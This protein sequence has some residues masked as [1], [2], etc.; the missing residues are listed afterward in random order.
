MTFASFATYCIALAIAVV[1]PGPGVMALIGT[2]LGGG[3]KRAMPMIIGIA[4]GDATWLT[5]AVL[6]LAAISEVY[7]EAFTII[8]YLGVAYLL[9]LAWKF[10]TNT[11]ELKAEEGASKRSAFASLLNGYLITMGNPKPMLFYLA[12]V[13]VILDLSAFGPTELSLV[14]VATFV[15]LVVVLTPY[16]LLASGAREWLKSSRV[17]KIMNRTAAAL[18]GTAAIVIGLRAH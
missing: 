14:V 16:A 18:I 11:S 3:L 17:Y 5:M 15:V 6:G 9:Y 4:F 8:R 7:A 2:A 13:P 12:L 1:I 10:W